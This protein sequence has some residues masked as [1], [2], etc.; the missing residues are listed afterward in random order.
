MLLQTIYIPLNHKSIGACS[1]KTPGRRHQIDERNQ[2]ENVLRVR[3]NIWLH[4]IFYRETNRE[5][6][7]GSIRIIDHKIRHVFA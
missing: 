7:T 6:W 5:R 2:I 4:I 3:S 1:P